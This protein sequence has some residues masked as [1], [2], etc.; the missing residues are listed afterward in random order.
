MTEGA[1]HFPTI[2]DSPPHSRRTFN[3]QETCPH[4][5]LI[6]DSVFSLCFKILTI[7]HSS[8]ISFLKNLVETENESCSRLQTPLFLLISSFRSQSDLALL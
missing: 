2:Y 3:S 4:L 6:T 7:L 8:F 5:H 1:A